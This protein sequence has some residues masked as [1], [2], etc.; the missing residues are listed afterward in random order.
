MLLHSP[1]KA[2]FCPVIVKEQIRRVAEPVWCPKKSGGGKVGKRQGS[3][4]R[5][6]FF[7]GVFF[8]PPGSTDHPPFLF[9]AETILDSA[10]RRLVT[11][12]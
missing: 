5:F 9:T 6:Y 4:R 1:Q 12:P 8:I 10:G 2:M 11:S 3:A 7:S